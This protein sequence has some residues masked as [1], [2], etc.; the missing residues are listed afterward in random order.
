MSVL[1][2]E[3]GRRIGGARIGDEL[4]W[5]IFIDNELD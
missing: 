2:Q 1:L 3:S 5:R 4:D